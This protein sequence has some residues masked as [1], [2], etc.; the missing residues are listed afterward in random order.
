MKLCLISTMLRRH[1]TFP[2][3]PSS[4]PSPREHVQD[5]GLTATSTSGG[6]IVIG[7]GVEDV[8]EDDG[9][10]DDGDHDEEDDGDVGA[11]W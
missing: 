1:F 4:P 11:G 9:G 7:L 3:P 5:V 2:P 6:K 8:D 10:D